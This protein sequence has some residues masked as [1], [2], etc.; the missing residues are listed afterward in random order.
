MRGDELLDAMEGIDKRYIEDAAKTPRRKRPVWLRVT[1]AA[2]CVCLLVCGVWQGWRWYAFRS[3]ML[4]GG[5]VALPQEAFA[6]SD[7]YDTLSELLEGLSGGEEHLSTRGDDVEIPV[8]AAEST[9]LTE[10]KNAVVYNGYSYHLGRQQIIISSLSGNTPQA[11]GVIDVDLTAVSLKEDQHAYASFTALFLRDDRLIAVN[12]LEIEG[13]KAVDRGTYTVVTVYSLADP[14][15]PALLHCFVQLGS[16][17]HVYMAGDT[18]MLMTADGVC[19]CGWSRLKNTEDYIPQLSVDGAAVAWGEE[20]LHILGTP[21]MVRYLAVTQIDT[22]TATVTD[23]HAFYGYVTDVYYGADWFA[24][25]VVEDVDKVYTFTVD[26][27]IQYTG[28]FAMPDPTFARTSVLSVAK[29]N[30]VYRVVSEYSTGRGGNTKTSL[31]G[32]TANIRTGKSY[33]RL[34]QLEQARLWLLPEVYWE[35]DSAVIVVE[36]ALLFAE[37]YGMS[38]RLHETPFAAETIRNVWGSNAH[39]T[40]IDLSDGQYL[41]FNATTDGLE[42]WDLSRSDAPVTRL[43]ETVLSGEERFDFY[44]TVYDKHTIGVAVAVPDENGKHHQS[45][46]LWH[47]YRLDRT[48][49]T[50]FELLAV[51]DLKTEPDFAVSFNRFASFE[52]EGQHYITTANLPVPLAVSW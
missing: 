24:L 44:W 22:A 4:E 1:A 26:D 29:D 19:A 20:R 27:G 47:I 18:L 9:A 13:G 50:P 39:K 3:T 11:V 36:D 52:Y 6:T 2:A 48:G 46:M 12:T 10:G 16:P 23:H 51:Y 42:L 17:T 31:L 34:L 35:E 41:R 14:A 45:N 5:A 38:V 15:T 37:F 30:E 43:T 7:T 49:K 21:T 28:V 33:Y 8:K 40:L 32:M 25:S